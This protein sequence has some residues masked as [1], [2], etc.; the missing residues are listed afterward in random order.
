MKK[1]LI[2]N[3]GEIAVRIIRAA[4]SLGI[5]TVAIYSDADAGTLHT[6]LADEKVS[7]RGSSAKDT[8]LNIEKILSAA[9][10]SGADAIHPGYGFLAENAH[11][12]EAVIK[13]KLTFIGPSPEIIS[14][15]GDKVRAKIKAEELGVPTIPG[16]FVDK[17]ETQVLE[18]ARKAGF[19]LLVKAAHGGSGRGM[20]VVREEAELLTKI[21]EAQ[22]ESKAA[23]SRDEVFLERYL[24]RPRHIEVQIFGDSHG[25]VIHFGER[26]CSVQRRHQKIIEE[27]PAPGLHTKVREKILEAARKLGKGVGYTNSGTVEFLLEDGSKAN[28]SFYFIEMNTRIQVEHTVTE[29]VYGVDLVSLQLKVAMGDKFEKSQ[30]EVVSTGHAIQYRIYAEN[31][32]KEFS[33]LTGKLLYISRPGGIGYREDS[34]V[35][36]GTKI[37]PYYDSLLSKLI[38]TGT[39]REEALFRSRAALEEFH[40]E[41]FETTLGFHRWILNNPDFI[42]SNIDV[43]WISRNY[44]G[45]TLP[46]KRFVAPFE[47]PVE[48]SS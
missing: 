13:Q 40:V 42:S 12:A 34:W 37:S 28:S 33:P 19:P 48:I 5:K 7:L 36:G 44:H 1:L 32:A 35:E 43:Y 30:K 45:E 31:P 4:R 27:A 24:E 10:I 6:R 46:P 23:F 14:L 25:N 8:Y 26:E 11:F 22:A 9:T 16:I 39:T 3:R 2:A 41:G 15:M 21:A 18:F 29:E 17:N 38:I 20:R 47:L